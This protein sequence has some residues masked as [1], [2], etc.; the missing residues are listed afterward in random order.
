MISMRFW[1]STN[2]SF[3]FVHELA[4]FTFR[5]S[6]CYIQLIKATTTS[7][8]TSNTL[9]TATSP[10][11]SIF[12][13]ASTSTVPTT[14]IPT[15]TIVTTI[16]T[17]TKS[18]TAIPITFTTQT[19]PSSSAITCDGSIDVAYE[20]IQCGDE[21]TSKYLWG[22]SCKAKKLFSTNFVTGVCGLNYACVTNDV[23][24]CP[25]NEFCPESLEGM[26]N[27][28]IKSLCVKVTLI[29]FLFDMFVYLLIFLHIYLVVIT[30][31]SMRQHHREQ[32]LI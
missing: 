8:A 19:V 9:T 20:C 21:A 22:S 17:T 3:Q 12:L 15:T 10:K 7:T 23:G 2:Y 1:N 24:K 13:S 6:F 26:S 11:T 5:I 14:S 4:N 32:L 28:N 16:A 27:S 31:L 25:Y 30:N 29:I 18:T